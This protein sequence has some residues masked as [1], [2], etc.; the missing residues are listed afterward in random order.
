VSLPSAP[1]SGLELERIGEATIPDVAAVLT[2]ATL[3]ESATP[4]ARAVERVAT[5]R[6]LR[7]LLL[8]NP[9][10]EAS[11][12]HGLCVRA[13]GGEI[14]GVLLSF[15]AAFVADE[16]RLLAFGSGGY[17]VQAGARTAGYYL[18]KRHL[19]M[20][21]ADFFFSTTCNA[22]SGRL[23]AALG[24]LAVHRSETEYILPLN[25]EVVLAAFVAGRAASPAAAGVAAALGRC[26]DPVW[27]RLGRPC[28]L[29]LEAC[30][31]WDKLA[32]LA[33]RHRPAGVITIDRSP[34]YLQWRYGPD[35]PN[36]P[37]EIHVVRDRLGDEGWFALG[38]VRRGREG[39]I[40]GA[41]V[42]D[43]VWPSARMRFA[44]LVPAIVRAAAPAV[45]AIYAHARPA[46][47]GG[48]GGRPWLPW[49]LD[50]PRAFVI[51]PRG[52][53]ARSLSS[54]DLVPADGD[55]AF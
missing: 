15:P 2:A 33:R 27:R 31:D 45:D 48:P 51:T 38:T 40:R 25:L 24:A 6:H 21:G 23:W 4:G 39:R 22:T 16:K 44:D 54:L 1:A 12:Y 8:D 9:L 5:E 47:A 35:A 34:A 13:A 43:A 55:G 26:A 30:R 28:T 36:G 17:A 42:L 14:T 11:P 53:A 32:A 10:A 49:R 7:W 37:F 20:A 19:T 50:G 46:L 3:S 29:A 18:F 52:R 41:I